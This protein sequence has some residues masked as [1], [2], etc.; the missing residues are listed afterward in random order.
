MLVAPLKIG[1]ALSGTLVFYY[2]T[3]QRFDEIRTRD[4]G[5]AR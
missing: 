1:G 4:G 2:R 5:R 3:P